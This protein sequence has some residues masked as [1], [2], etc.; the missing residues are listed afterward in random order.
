MRRVGLRTLMAGGTVVA[1]LVAEGWM[2]TR[3]EYLPTTPVLE[4]G[5]VLGPEDGEPLTLAVLGDSSVA[6]VGADRAED[7]LTYGVA[8]CLAA[9]YRV[10]LHALGVSGARLA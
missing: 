3:R 2:A 7:T 8:K 6:G 1:T 9:R 5:G 4:I 10:T